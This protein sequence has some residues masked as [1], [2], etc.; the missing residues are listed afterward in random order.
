MGVDQIF[1]VDVIANSGSVG[2]REVRAEEGEGVPP[3]GR[4]VKRARDQVCFWAVI[5]TD[6]TS[7]AGNVEIAE[8]RAGETIRFRMGC[9]GALRGELRGTIRV[10]RLQ[11]CIL[12][13]WNLLRGSVDRGRRREDDGRHA[14]V[15]HRVQHNKGTASIDPPI[16]RRI[17]HRLGVVL[18]KRGC[19]RGAVT[20][21][22]PRQWYAVWQRVLMAL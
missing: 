9:D 12:R 4:S 7:R 3:A 22:D 20:D 11:R 13:N 18:T 17:A 21:V 8:S 15:A 6:V 5:L 2:G 16:R 1:D 14:G 10:D 19:Q